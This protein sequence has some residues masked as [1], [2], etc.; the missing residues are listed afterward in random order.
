[1]LSSI[2]AKISGVLA[3][4]GG[5]L[6]LMLRG[7]KSKR[8][9]AELEASIEK[10][11][12][13]HLEKDRVIISNIDEEREEWKNQQ[14]DEAIYNAQFTENLKSNDDNHAVVDQLTSV[15]NK[16]NSKDKDT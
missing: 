3:V 7:E 12:R 2:W 15:L 8:K 13:E 1:M 6:L 16:N 11:N 14:S 10:G 5:I 4:I 9:A